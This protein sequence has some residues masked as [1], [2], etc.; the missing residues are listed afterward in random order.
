[1]GKLS[2]AIKEYKTSPMN[3]PAERAAKEVIIQI[4]ESQWWKDNV[5]KEFKMPHKYDPKKKTF[6]FRE[7]QFVTF[8]NLI[9]PRH[10]FCEKCGL[11]K[12]GLLTTNKGNMLYV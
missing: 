3:S 4:T 8:G 7:P 9:R 11:D 6:G 12:Q 2:D 1:M 10:E 5:G